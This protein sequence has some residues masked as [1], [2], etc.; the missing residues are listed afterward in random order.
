M[1]ALRQCDM[2]AELRSI[3]ELKKTKDELDWFKR[4]YPNHP[5]YPDPSSKHL[6]END[7]EEIVDGY[8][9]IYPSTPMSDVMIWFRFIYDGQYDHGL[10]SKIVMDKIVDH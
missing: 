4:I 9:D 5:D 3:D 7:L 2:E 8:I 1:G 6:S 10:L